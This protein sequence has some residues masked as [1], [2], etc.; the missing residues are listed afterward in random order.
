MNMKNKKTKKT[1]LVLQPETV[2]ITRCLRKHEVEQELSPFDLDAHTIL[3][4]CFVCLQ[5]QVKRAGSTASHQPLQ[6]VGSALQVLLQRA[7]E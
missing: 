6:E 3:S 5:Q 4:F 7:Q 2:L 1:S